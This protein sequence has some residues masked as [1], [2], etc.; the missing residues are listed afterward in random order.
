ME[1]Q[2]QQTLEHVELDLPNGLTGGAAEWPQETA[3]AGMWPFEQQHAEQQDLDLSACTALL[4]QQHSTVMQHGP[5]T[6][7]QRHNESRT[8]DV[9][10]Q[11]HNRTWSR[12]VMQLLGSTADAAE[13][14]DT[15]I[16]SPDS[17]DQNFSVLMPIWLSPAAATRQHQS[18]SSTTRMPVKC[19]L[20]SLSL[21][22]AAAAATAAA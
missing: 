22:A 1:V 4:S 10:K 3:C 16:P 19:L 13:W 7:Q 9:Q 6:A 14:Q 17:G 12:A 15:G 8:S 11:Q 18:T 20:N 21:P 5:P 2:V